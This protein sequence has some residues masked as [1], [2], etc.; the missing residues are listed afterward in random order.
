MRKSDR[1]R[2]G[3]FLLQGHRNPRGYRTSGEAEDASSGNDEEA[4]NAGRAERGPVVEARLV[5]RLLL[6]ALVRRGARLHVQ[7]RRHRLVGRHP[8][9]EGG[10]AR[11]PLPPLAGLAAWVR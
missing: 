8:R 2:G 4:S 1:K 11:M 7:R 9:L 5:K 3:L 6:R 10:E